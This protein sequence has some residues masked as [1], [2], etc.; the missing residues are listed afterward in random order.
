MMKGCARELN[1]RGVGQH[2]LGVGIFP[3]TPQIS[4]GAVTKPKF[5]SDTVLYPQK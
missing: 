1:L 2:C 5:T 3:L 4:L